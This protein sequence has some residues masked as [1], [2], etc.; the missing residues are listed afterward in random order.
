MLYL[1]IQGH[2]VLILSF[3]SSHLSN[4]LHTACA[5]AKVLGHPHNPAHRGDVIFPIILAGPP[6]RVNCHHL[7]GAFLEVIPQVSHLGTTPSPIFE[8]LL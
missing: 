2:C 6:S 3:C 7:L 5:S 4:L 1:G 8:H